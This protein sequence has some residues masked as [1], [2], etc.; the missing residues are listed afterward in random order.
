MARFVIPFRQNGKTRLGDSGLAR[1]M[2]RDVIAA[3]GELEQLVESAP[4]LVAASDGTTNALALRDAGDFAPLYGP[5]SA[6][7]FEEHLRAAPL[8]LAGIRDD[9]DTWADL[10]RMRGRV[11]E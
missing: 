4:A 2:L 6:A 9:V 11:G 10:E 1:A 3:V 5:G 7:R 8:E